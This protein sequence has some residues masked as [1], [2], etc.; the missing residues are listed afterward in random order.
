MTAWADTV[1]SKCRYHE[2]AEVIFGDAEIIWER[3]EHDYQG[4]VNVLAK[5][6][7]GTFAHMRYDYGSCSGCDEWETRDLSDEQVAVEIRR[8]MAVFAVAD[9]MAHYLRRG[10]SD[11]FTAMQSA[12][13]PWEKAGR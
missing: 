11:D 13:V 12:F 6:A 7:D 9:R 5:L 4:E 3:S 8:E 10:N 1:A 2:A